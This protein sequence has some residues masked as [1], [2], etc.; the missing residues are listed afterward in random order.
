M[1]FHPDIDQ[2]H[3]KGA[4]TLVGIETKNNFAARISNYAWK[5]DQEKSFYVDHSDKV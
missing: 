4:G 5:S 2:N 1:K 3:N